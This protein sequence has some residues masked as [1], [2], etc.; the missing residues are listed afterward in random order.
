MVGNGGYTQYILNNKYSDKKKV[1]NGWVRVGILHAY[2]IDITIR[3]C[4]T[5]D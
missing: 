2:K 5:L 4:Q 1:R 3:N